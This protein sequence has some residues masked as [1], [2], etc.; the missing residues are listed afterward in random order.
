MYEY[1]N[2][3][4]NTVPFLFEQ[5]AFI[6]ILCLLVIE[7][8]SYLFFTFSFS[9]LKKTFKD[10][11]KFKHPWDFVVLFTWLLLAFLSVLYFNNTSPVSSTFLSAGIALFVLGWLIRHQYHIERILSKRC[12]WI[13]PF[14]VSYSN[15]WGKLKFYDIHARL[16]G[17]WLEI[18]AI[19]L[20]AKT[21]II[22]PA[23]F[24]FPLIL[25]TS[26]IQHGK[27]LALANPH[28][29][30]LAFKD[31]FPKLGHILLFA[32]IP[33]S[34]A[35]FVGIATRE[36]AI[37]Y[38]DVETAKSVLFTL[39]QI[40]GGIGVLAITIIFVLTQLTASNYSIRTSAILFCQ[41]AFW[42]P[43][44]IL[45]G[46]ITYNLL[47]AS[48]SPILFPSNADYFH[49]LIVDLSFV[50]GLATACSIAYFIFKAPR[51]VSPESII[52]NSLKSFDKEWLDTI[53]NDWCRPNFPVKLNIRD[54]PFIV[55]ER[56][57]SRAVDS[58]DSLTFVSGL[59]LI[60]DRLR[61][62]KTI[63]P[64]ELPNYIIEIDA[65]LR[66]HFR[67]LVRTAAKNSDAYTLL[68]LIN[69]IEELGDPSSESITKCDTF[70]FGFDE[71]AG[72]LLLR[73][74]IRQSSAYQLTECVTRG[75]H[76]VESRAVEVLNTLPNQINTWLYDPPKR[77][78]K[79][80]DEEEKTLQANDH[81]VENFK[82]QY[83]SYFESLGV[84]AANSK[85]T[86][87]VRTVT[88][89][90]NNIISSIIQ[91]INGHT[92]KA[93]I[94]THALWSLDKIRE[95]SCNNKLSDAMSL[96][97]LDHAAEHTHA[98]HDEA[99]A[100]E[101]V[102]YVSDFL[103]GHA[104]LGLLHYMNVVD[105][106]MIGLRIVEKYT[107]PAIRL[108]KSL[109]E[110]AKLLK[111]NKNYTENKD[112]QLVYDEII[113]RIRQVGHAGPRKDPEQISSTVKSVLESLSEP[114]FEE[115]RKA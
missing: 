45:F 96:T 17:P 69:F 115:I 58:G 16:F 40:E 82:R 61:T 35:V 44:I 110:A 77:D 102:H 31:L 34:I 30:P 6:V 4:T 84:T 38:N 98:E 22:F 87:I 63:D 29:T 55:I 24:I 33:L 1:I 56:I 106:A 49:S 114:E 52:A 23:F 85:S 53:K 81:R 48:R 65:Y 78:A 3:F 70:A 90:L 76:I 83:F 37:F 104:K 94:V 20:I 8:A 88:L 62:I 86:E 54:D 39:S 25:G 9:K 51:M 42:L 59:I 108:L 43:L 7:L 47:V 103:L 93:M 79:L 2:L 36:F 12:R 5:V 80:S 91:H 66:H 105:S 19:S 75:I 13:R 100:W 18:V 28:I 27:K 95:A 73:E 10:I 107:K 109:G 111:Q 21:I 46:S 60:R 32:V 15:F 92:L 26:I 113:Q 67:S 50:F 71:A 68:Q 97:M 14:L 74:I 41:R 11:L 89:S 57:L 112:L 72:E 99:V 101:L 64:R